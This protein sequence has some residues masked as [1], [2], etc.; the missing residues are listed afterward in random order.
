MRIRVRSSDGNAQVN[1]V[2]A[3]VDSVRVTG[4]ATC[5]SSRIFADGFESGG[6]GAWSV[7]VP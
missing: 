7:V 6:T 3:A 1:V 5:R 2:E 4:P